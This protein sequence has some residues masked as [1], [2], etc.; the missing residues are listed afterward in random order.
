MKFKAHILSLVALIGFSALAETFYT[1]EDCIA[2]GLERAVPVMNAERDRQIAEATMKQARSRA[3]PQVTLTGSYLHSN[4]GATSD[5]LL[6]SYSGSTAVSQTLYDGGKVVSAIRAAKAYRGLTTQQKA[7]KT[8]TLIRDIHIAFNGILLAQAN[9]DVLDAS[10]NQLVDFE[11]QAKEKFEAG[12]ASEFDYLTA[13]VRLANEKPLLEEARNTL[14]IA[15]EQFRNLLVLDEEEYE[16]RGEL[17]YKPFNSELSHLQTLAA[18]SRPELRVQDATVELRREDLNSAWGGY[19]PTLTAS[20]AY[21]KESPGR[22][23]A[24][25]D[26]WEGHWEAGLTASWTL[27]DGGNRRGEVLAKGLELAKAEADQDDLRRAV[28]LDVKAAW[29][30]MLAA[31]KTIVGATKTVELAEKAL[32]ISRTRY[33]AGL[34]TTLEFTDSNLSLNTARL[35]RF[36]ALEKHSNA[37]VRL[38]YAAGLLTPEFGPD[39]K[40]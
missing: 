21:T 15:K 26:D 31:E 2:I 1:L 23:D 16:L 24:T 34:A 28:A 5:A 3:L 39:E 25:T 40:L 8:A 13:Q 19:K 37:I 10:V 20:A 30:D 7:Q 29:L 38:R 27:F 11:E 32:E 14:A 9:V 6:D 22:Y 33:D 4:E 18:T 17:E 35:T 36:Q 12:T